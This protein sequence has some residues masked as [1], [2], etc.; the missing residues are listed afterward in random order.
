MR[1]KRAPCTIPE[2]TALAVHMHVGP[3]SKTGLSGGKWHKFKHMLHAQEIQQIF[4]YIRVAD[5]ITEY[6]PVAQD[7]VTVQGVMT[8]YSWSIKCVQTTCCFVI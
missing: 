8:E 7:M 4:E 3:T 2:W 5:M 6:L 1:G